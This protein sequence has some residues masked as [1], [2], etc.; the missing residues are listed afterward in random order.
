[1]VDNLEVVCYTTPLQEAGV[2][3]NNLPYNTRELMVVKKFRRFG[4]IHR[5]LCMVHEKSQSTSVLLVYFSVRSATKA[6]KR[7]HQKTLFNR[8]VNVV[9][10]QDLDEYRNVFKISL[11]WCITISN[12]YFSPFGWTSEI[13]KVEK[14]EIVHISNNEVK[15]TYK[16]KVRL[17]FLDRV[18]VV[19]LGIGE[20]TAEEIGQA[21]HVAKKSAVSHAKL[22]A[23]NQVCIVLTDGQRP[24]PWLRDPAL[25]S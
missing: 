7:Y 18:D 10:Q 5:S 23:F 9:R 6:I 25:E 17:I 20:K 14:H 1:M 24:R 19:G 12:W 21:V 8:L 11:A 15:A 3:V 16:A 4:L 13:Q 22:N 2:W